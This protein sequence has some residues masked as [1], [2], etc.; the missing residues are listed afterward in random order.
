MTIVDELVLKRG[1]VILS[2][3]QHFSVSS[4]VFSATFKTHHSNIKKWGRWVTK[5]KI[6]NC[7]QEIVLSNQSEIS[8][9]NMLISKLLKK[10]R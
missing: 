9:Q 6:Q 2:H 7:T 3:R 5:N 8:A 10:F 4:L 1:M